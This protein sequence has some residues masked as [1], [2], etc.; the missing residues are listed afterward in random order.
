[1][2][3]DKKKP[4][5]TSPEASGR[6]LHLLL[7]PAAQRRAAARIQPILAQMTVK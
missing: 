3:G 2:V 7:D 5:K 1:M 6:A 4:R